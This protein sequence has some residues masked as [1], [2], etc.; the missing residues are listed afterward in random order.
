MPNLGDKNRSKDVANFFVNLNRL[1]N[2]AKKIPE[3]KVVFVGDTAVGKTS[4]IMRYQHNVFMTDFQSTVGAAFVSKTV[5]TKNGDANLHIWDT[6]GQERYRSLVPMYSRG[7]AAALIVFDVSEK[8]SFGGIESWV[9]QVRRDIPADC[10]IFI[11]GNKCDKEILVDKK[12]IEVF[13]AN[14]N[15]RL[16]FVSA[17]TGNGISELFKDVSESIPFDKFRNIPEELSF[18][19]STQ[20]RGNSCC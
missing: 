17:L 4:I 14:N 11:I 1:M 19:S 3:F 16:H 5:Q 13:A 6:A 8:E 18:S 10:T 9:N 20:K 12:E 2:L 15:L 7:A